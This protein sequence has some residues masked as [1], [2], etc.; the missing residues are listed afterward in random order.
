S[1]S[2]GGEGT[3]GALSGPGS[4]LS[5]DPIHRGGFCAEDWC[6]SAPLPQGDS[7]YEMWSAPGAGVWAIADSLGVLRWSGSAWERL[8]MPAQG[9]VSLWGT[10]AE[11]IYVG[12][13]NTLW[14]IQHDYISRVALPELDYAITHISGTGPNDV[15]I[16]TRGALHFDGT[17][18]TRPAGLPASEVLSD[19]LAV[20]PDRVWFRYNSPPSLVFWNGVSL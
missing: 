3:G 12:L 15:W 17:S 13:G 20:A 5:V 10:G 14:R 8:N 1:P 6:W 2:G 19:V 16:S 18:W 9:S 4:P 7:I 11:L